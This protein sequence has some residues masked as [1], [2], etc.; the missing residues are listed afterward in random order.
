[1]RCCVVCPAP[2]Q[3]MLRREMELAY[4]TGDFAKAQRLLARL[5]PEEK[6]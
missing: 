4:K 3:E 6:K 5:N 1:M 2:A